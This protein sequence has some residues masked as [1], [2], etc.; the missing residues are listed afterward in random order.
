M[1]DV[2]DGMPPCC[3][4]YEQRECLHRRQGCLYGVRG[5]CAQLP[6]RGPHCAGRGRMCCSGHQLRTWSGWFILLLCD[7]ACTPFKGRIRPTGSLQESRLLLS[8]PIGPKILLHHR[9]R[10][11]SPVPSLRY[12]S[13]ASSSSSPRFSRNSPAMGPAE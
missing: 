4:G 11:A 3:P 10:S 6:D 1:R 7:R 2:S 5:M 13:K 9:E 8:L 12:R